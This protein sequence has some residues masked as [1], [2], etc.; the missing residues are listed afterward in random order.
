MW[1]VKGSNDDLRVTDLELNVLNKSNIYI[2]IYIY[3]LFKKD[4][5]M[6]IYNEHKEVTTPFQSLNLKSSL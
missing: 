6:D 3:V 4:Y 1:C 5:L 2:Y